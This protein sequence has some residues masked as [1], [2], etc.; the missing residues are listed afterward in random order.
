MADVDPQQL[1]ASGVDPQTGSTVRNALLR[2]SVINSDAFKRQKDEEDA[3]NADLVQKQQTI[4]TS[5]NSSIQ[6]L[7]DDISRLGENISKISLSFYQDQ[8]TDQ[9]KIKNDQEYERKLTERQVRIGKE[10]ALEQKIQNAVTEP[11]QKLVPKVQDLFG[12][13]GAALSI[14][15][16]GWLT[17]QTIQALKASEENNTQKFNDIKYNIL[18]N[19]GLVVG[20]FIAIKTGFGL[21]TRTIARI[22]FGLTRLLIAKPLAAAA[23]LI[24]LPFRGGN[25]TP[26][27][28]GG[29]KGTQPP[30]G[31]K[32]GILNLL[33]KFAVGVTA[34]MNA[35]NGEYLDAVLGAIGMLGGPGKFFKIIRLA[36]DA[37]Q[38]AEIFGL[39]IFGKNPNDLKN[40]REV[41][42]LAEEEAK[43]NKNNP[44]AAST[45]PA[46]ST[47]PPPAPEKPSTQPSSTAQPSSPPT[48][49]VATPSADMVNKFEMAWKYRNNPMARGRIEGAWNEMSPE[50]KQQ[51]KDWAQSKGYN[52]SEMK[53]SEPQTAPPPKMESADIKP[54]EMTSPPKPPTSVSA[55]PEPKPTLTMIRTANNQQ[56]T[57]PTPNGSLTDVPLISSSNPDNFYVLYSQLSYN[58]VT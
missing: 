3:K 44:P 8:T 49:A 41:K 14:L 21:I 1:G 52:W 42:R 45:K 55:L 56:Q 33:G 16:G 50:Q 22:A 32:S 15:F 34:F 24:T 23:S 46:S 40:A 12:R 6:S 27:A 5:I 17:D 36:Y 31:G 54:A 13:V 57:S 9:N 2:T 30:G 18:K 28:G 19:V 47:T 43:K 7:R 20:G 39:N 25:R 38:I 4:Y 51:A 26:P 37:D 53:L 35:K 48:P 10:N 58:V 29:G 11:V